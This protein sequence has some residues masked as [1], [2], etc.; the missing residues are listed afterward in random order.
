MGPLVCLA[1]PHPLS[2]ATLP[3][4]G[5]LARASALL[6]MISILFEYLLWD[7]AA[8]DAAAGVSVS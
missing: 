4:P 6:W 5:R 1:R 8:I 3:G 2:G 7:L